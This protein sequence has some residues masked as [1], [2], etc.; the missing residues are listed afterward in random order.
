M[1]VV[2][3]RLTRLDESP[4]QVLVHDAPEVVGRL[5][6]GSALLVRLLESV[7]HEAKVLSEQRTPVV[8]RQ[9]V[10]IMNGT[11]V[12][13]NQCVGCTRQF[14]T[15]SFLGDDAAVLAR[16]NGGIATPSSMRRLDGVQVDATIQH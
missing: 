6:H 9:W 10:R 16:P 1:G 8:E 7:I 14:F 13:I 12:E 3:Q 5:R 15:K 2:A 11:C 4:T